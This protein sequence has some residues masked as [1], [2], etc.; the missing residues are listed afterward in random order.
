M[1][2]TN[3]T[4]FQSEA[5]LQALGFRPAA[6]YS[7]RWLVAAG[8][9][10]SKSEM[11]EIANGRLKPCVGSDPVGNHQERKGRGSP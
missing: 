9:I 2:S 5:A 11:G 6:G 8:E 10:F 1:I 4:T 7:G 3:T